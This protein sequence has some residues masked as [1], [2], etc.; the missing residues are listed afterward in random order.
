SY[1]NDEKERIGNYAIA[2]L[3][4]DDFKCINDGFGHKVGDAALVSLSQI[5]KS[6]LSPEDLAVRWGGEEFIVFMRDTDGEKAYEKISGILERIREEK[7]KA[8]DRLISYTFT[9]GLASS[10]DISD[11][12]KVIIEADSKLYIGKNSG[13]NRIIS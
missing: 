13:K 7:I 4:I 11:C 6:K 10:D 5:L 1:I 3:D 2:L 9:A 12:E 8:D